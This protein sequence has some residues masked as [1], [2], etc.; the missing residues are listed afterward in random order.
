M[1]TT[2]TPEFLL[3]H[4]FSYSIIFILAFIYEF[5]KQKSRK[6]LKG[7]LPICSVCKKIRDDK[8]YWNQIEGYIQKHSDAQ[9]SHGICPDCSKKYYTVFVKKD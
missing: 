6:E 3:M 8:G 9:F 4:F 7:L 2:Y 1:M 5:H